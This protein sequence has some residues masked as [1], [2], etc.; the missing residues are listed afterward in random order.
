MRIGIPILSAMNEET[1]IARAVRLLGGQGATARAVG[2]KQ[3]SVWGWL[4]N[5]KVTAEYVLPLERATHGE[6]TRHELRP[7]LYPLEAA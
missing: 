5:G 4:Q 3:P 6:V 1:P 2:V 7:D